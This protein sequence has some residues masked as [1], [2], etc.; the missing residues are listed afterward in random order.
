[1]ILS[2]ESRK[3]NNF[4]LGLVVSY[5]LF[6][7]TVP[8]RTYSAMSTRSDK[9]CHPCLVSDLKLRVFFGTQYD[10]LTVGFSY[11]ASTVFPYTFSI[12]DSLGVF[13]I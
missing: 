2:F 9:T 4:L 5:F 3:L 12:P 7:P 6:L 8:V 1:M 13:I 10:G 11:V